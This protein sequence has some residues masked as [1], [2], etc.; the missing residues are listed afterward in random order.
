MAKLVS[1]ECS[2]MLVSLR[3]IQ[4]DYKEVTALSAYQ[5]STWL[6]RHFLYATTLCIVQQYCAA[7][8]RTGQLE[9]RVQVRVA[10]TRRLCESVPGKCQ[11]VTCPRASH[12]FKVMAAKQVPYLCG[13]VQQFLGKDLWPPV[14]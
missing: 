9:K 11:P 8:V 4:H 13:G 2:V 12:K 14:D 5:H 1:W 10:L 6:N 3:C 7:R